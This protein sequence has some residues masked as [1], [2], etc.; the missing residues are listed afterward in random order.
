M[1]TPLPLS[2]A[3]A[4]AIATGLVIGVLI[5]A[6]YLM[7]LLGLSVDRYDPRLVLRLPDLYAANRD[8][9]VIALG[10]L[11]APPLL[12]SLLAAIWTLQRRRDDYGAAHWQTPRELRENGMLQA[13]P[14]DGF[15]CAKLG[16][17]KSQAP[18]VSCSHHPHVLMV[19]PTRAGKGVGCV[20]P[21]LLTFKGSIIALDVKG[22]LFQET[23]RA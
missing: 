8:A 4:A 16:A 21:N 1:K 20:I 13:A 7:V 18:F 19:A 12:L 5:T 10:L 9:A 22:E 2:A 23:S 17:P 11:L 3:M 15:V 6:I 14:G